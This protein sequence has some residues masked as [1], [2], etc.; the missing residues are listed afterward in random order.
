MAKI[1][2]RQEFDLMKL[3][4]EDDNIV[5]R[6]ISQGVLN[7]FENGQKNIENEKWTLNN[8]DQNINKKK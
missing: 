6:L 1:K 3:C 4:V 2:N 7:Q 8:L 5:S